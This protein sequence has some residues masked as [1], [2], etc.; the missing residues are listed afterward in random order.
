[1]KCYIGQ[2][3]HNRLCPTLL[4]VFESFAILGFD[5][6]FLYDRELKTLVANKIMSRRIKAAVGELTRLDLIDRNC[7]FRIDALRKANVWEISENPYTCR[8]S[9]NVCIDKGMSFF[10]HIQGIPVCLDINEKVRFVLLSVQ[11]SALTESNVILKDLSADRVWKYSVAQQRFLPISTPFFSDVELE[12]LRL[13]SLGF[14]E[15]QISRHIFKSL[16]AIKKHKSAMFDRLNV[17]NIVQVIS[18]A[19][20]HHLM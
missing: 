18:Y 11:Y 6:L 1:M 14:T 17:R 10:V 16:P 13:T 8:L 9:M 2:P 12:I 3:L 20:L 15:Q 4:S 5:A 7:L 19:R